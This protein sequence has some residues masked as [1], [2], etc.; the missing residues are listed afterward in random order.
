MKILKILCH[1]EVDRMLYGALGE[2]L[3]IFRTQDYTYW[4][5]DHQLGVPV[6]RDI[7]SIV[8]ND[9]D[10]VIVD[11][12]RT[13]S[14]ITKLKIKAKAFVWYVHG[15][16]HTWQGFQSFANERLKDYNFIFTDESRLNYWKSW[17][18]NNFNKYITLPIHL[19]DFYFTPELPITRNGAVYSIGSE[20]L[21]SSALYGNS[22]MSTIIALS[23]LGLDRYHIYGYGNKKIPI[24]KRHIK[25]FSENIRNSLNGY[26]ASAHPSEVQTLGFALLESMAAGVPVICTPKIDFV[27]YRFKD[28]D[29]P[30]LITNTPQEFYQYAKK[31]LKSQAYCDLVAYNARKFLRENYPFENY[32]QKINYWLLF[33]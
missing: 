23:I 16:Y 5:E 13:W 20:L 4:I 32:K 10:I 30:F 3:K 17:Y 22:A 12:T 26:S 6:T 33:L 28:G 18:K 19:Q 15:S 1:L 11:D 7:D 31:F 8:N 21:K 9:W 24:N 25:S 2:Q 29:A 27:K 14:D